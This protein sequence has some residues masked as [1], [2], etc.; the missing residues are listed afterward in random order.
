MS[1]RDWDSIKRVLIQLFWIQSLQ[2]DFAIV[3][4]SDL[5]KT[6][7]FHWKS[8]VHLVVSIE[9]LMRVPL[10]PIVLLLNNRS[11]SHSYFE[12]KKVL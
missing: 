5:D 11:S 1:S 9:A 4:H 7:E 3:F 2:I 10:K 12:R 8:Q 6:H